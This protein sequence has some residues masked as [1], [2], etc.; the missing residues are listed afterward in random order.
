MAKHASSPPDWR[1]TG[2]T[3]TSK[4]KL[5]EN[6]AWYPASLISGHKEEPGRK[7]GSI[8]VL[9]LRFNND[10]FNQLRTLVFRLNATGRSPGGFTGRHGFARDDFS[11][12]KM[13]R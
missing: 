2:S 12:R 6:A 4:N 5:Q 13:D 7:P 1:S 11:I 8:N 10:K 9:F 3:S